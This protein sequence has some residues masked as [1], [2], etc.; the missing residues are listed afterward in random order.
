MSL[1][2]PQYIDGGRL[3]LLV[4]LGSRRLYFG[5]TEQLPQNAPALRVLG[6][7]GAKISMKICDLVLQRAHMET[8]IISIIVD[9][10]HLQLA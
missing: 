6:R 10:D 1:Q 3:A 7:S 4:F 2:S 5:A 8:Q 9:L